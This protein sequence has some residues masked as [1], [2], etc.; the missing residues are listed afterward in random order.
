[1]QKAHALLL[2]V[3]FRCGLVLGMLASITG[4]FLNGHLGGR[5]WLEEV[6]YWGEGCPGGLVCTPFFLLSQSWLPCLVLHCCT[7]CSLQNILPQHTWSQ[8]TEARDLTSGHGLQ[9]GDGT[10]PSPL[11]L[12]TA[13]GALSSSGCCGQLWLSGGRWRGV[14]C[15]GT[16]GKVRRLF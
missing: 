2:L 12:S 7:S 16:L 5:V 10:W 8:N 6:V 9:L 13:G 11:P 14:M 3:Q 1:M 15:P 4:P